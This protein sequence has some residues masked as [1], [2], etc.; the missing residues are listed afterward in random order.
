MPQQKRGKPKKSHWYEKKEAKKLKKTEAR[1]DADAIDVNDRR[2]YFPTT[3]H[4]GSYAVH[5]H[6]E[7]TTDK[8]GTGPK[9]RYGLLIAYS[10]R[11]YSG[12]Q[13]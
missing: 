6:P 11:Q 2:N 8:C 1:G 12:M 9:R 4:P 13:M 5:L 3:I 7:D 10:G